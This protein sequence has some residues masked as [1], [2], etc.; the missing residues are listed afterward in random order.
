MSLLTAILLII[1][2]WACIATFV[3]GESRIKFPEREFVLAGCLFGAIA[4]C[5]AFL[6][7]YLSV[8]V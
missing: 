5:C 6:A 4:L 3:C 2:L 7:G 1:S 8:G